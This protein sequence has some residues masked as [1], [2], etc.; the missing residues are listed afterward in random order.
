MTL[1]ALDTSPH[2]QFGNR[3]V[4]YAIAFSIVGHIVVLMLSPKV[5]IWNPI[6]RTPQS[7]EI[8]A[9]HA[10]P[11]LP[12]KSKP[13]KPLEEIV[14]KKKRRAHTTR[15]EQTA[16]AEV[17]KAPLPLDLSTKAILR[18]FGNDE[19]ITTDSETLSE[20]GAVV[21][22]KNLLAALN[23]AERARP[24][25]NSSP[26]IEAGVDGVSQT[27]FIQVNDMCFKVELENPLAPISREM[28]FRV[29]C[30]L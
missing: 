12:Q 19:S 11:T 1:A 21:M 7:I 17:E 15:P 25:W 14:I 28:W 9:R 24:I 8:R 29:K 5:S 3:G 16:P 20:N 2:Y 30:P 23:N 26:T 18:N 22:N 13:E 27:E 6:A 10:N 4:Y